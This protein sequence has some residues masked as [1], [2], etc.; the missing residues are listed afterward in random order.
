MDSVKWLLGLKPTRAQPPRVPTDEVYPVHY[1][2]DTPANRKQNM[3][4]LLRFE[5]VLDVDMLQ[6]S[7]T[8]LLQRDGWRKIAGRIRLT[9]SASIALDVDHSVRPYEYA[10]DRVPDI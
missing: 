6:D 7:L 3:T 10:P 4:W 8:R 1:L 2:D 5:D 9:V